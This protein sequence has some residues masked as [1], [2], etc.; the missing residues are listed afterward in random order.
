MAVKLT[1]SA[2]RR[3]RVASAPYLVALVRTGAAFTGGKLAWRPG[4]DAPPE[5]A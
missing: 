1:G 2:Q 3:W 4:E 5:A